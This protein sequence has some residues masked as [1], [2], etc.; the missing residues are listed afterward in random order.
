M[1]ME[2]KITLV[3]FMMATI[4]SIGLTSIP[5]ASAIS[6][7][8]GEN[9]FSI[10]S[11]S[12]TLRKINPDTGATI[13]TV[14]ITLAGETVNGGRDLA[15]NPTDG[16]LYA[17]LKID[18]AGDT[19]LVTLNLLT[20]V[21]TLIG[22]TGDR[23]NSMAFNAGS[24][25]ASTTNSAGVSNTLFSMSTVDASSTNLCLLD[26]GSGSSL[27]FNPIDGK[28]YHYTVNAAGFNRIDNTA[29]CTIVNIPTTESTQFSTG[30][31]FRTQ[32]GL[33][34]LGQDGSELFTLSAAGVGPNSL[35]FIATQPGG[36]AIIFLAP[37][38][39]TFIPIDQ[40]ALLL[41][42]VQSISMWMIPVVVAG[43]VIG[44]F[45]IKRRN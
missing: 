24:L 42:G 7:S 32:T 36:L 15:F 26:A 25:F 1:G 2:R 4:F 45:V 13:D 14:T 27:G 33:F 19:F 22:D 41:A 20:G 31:T 30:L 34:L 23:F 17:F 5:F 37:I 3:A 43:V 35:S 11:F 21:A 39:G 16:K 8:P 9:V 28:L 29:T 6:I 38:G 12:P 44:V 18:G 40:S 10:D